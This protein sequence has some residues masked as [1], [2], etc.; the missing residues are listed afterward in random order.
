LGTT[1]RPT[2]LSPR[3]SLQTSKLEGKRM[4]WYGATALGCSA[5]LLDGRHKL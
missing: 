1:R 4:R 3:Q 2:A 5:L